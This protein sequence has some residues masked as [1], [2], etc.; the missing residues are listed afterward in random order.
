MLCIEENAPRTVAANCFV[1]KS[2]IDECEVLKTAKCSRK[3]Q[4]ILLPWHLFCSEL[5]LDQ[6]EFELTRWKVVR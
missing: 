6:G 5:T 1:Y 4:P 3:Y 2:K